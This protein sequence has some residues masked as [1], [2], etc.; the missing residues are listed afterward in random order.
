M[1]FGTMISKLVLFLFYFDF[2]P[3]LE[4]SK[5]WIFF[6]SSIFD[7]NFWKLVNT[8]YLWV[9]SDKKYKIR[10]Q[11]RD[12]V[13]GYLCYSSPGICITVTSVILTYSAAQVFEISNLFKTL[14]AYICMRPDLRVSFWFGRYSFFDQKTYT[15]AN[16]LYVSDQIA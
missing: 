9:S 15:Q 11:W 10:D 12:L 1:F 16:F 4:K 13:G 6:T 7:K 2:P 5:F 14:I 3:F 8:L